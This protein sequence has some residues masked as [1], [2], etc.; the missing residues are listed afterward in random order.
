MILL[1]RWKKNLCLGI[2]GLL[3][4]VCL[5]SVVWSSDE[6]PTNSDPFPKNYMIFMLFPENDK[7]P[8]SNDNESEKTTTTL[9]SEGEKNPVNSLTKSLSVSSTQL[10]KKEK[11]DESLEILYPDD[12]YNYLIQYTIGQDE[13]MRSLSTFIHQHLM[14]VHL[15]QKAK[16]NPHDEDL[17]G[18]VIEKPNILMMGPTGCGKTSS[19]KE[20]SKLLKVPFATGNATEWTAQGYIGGKWQDTFDMLVSN[21]QSILTSQ[22]KPKGNGEVLKLASQGIVFID[23]FDKICNKTAGELEV[24]DRV[25]QELLPVIQGTEIKLNSGDYLDTSNILFIAGGAFPG[26]IPNHQDQETQK[27]SKKHNKTPDVIT[28]AHLEKYGMLPELAGRLCNIVQFSPLDKEALKK[29]ILNSKTSALKQSVKYY[30]AAYK[31]DLTID[32]M[33]V[34]YI[35]EAA[36][37]QK[38]GARG[39]NAMLYKLME[40]K[41]FNIKKYIG[42][43]VKITV[44]DARKVLEPYIKELK[45]DVNPSHLMMYT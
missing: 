20:V 32:D 12:I 11:E 25:Q 38:T 33:V 44:E 6:K 4:N 3:F 7:A 21:A 22:K 5:S 27:S 24:I 34:D 19:L 29:I 15:R 14:M 17:K 39:I 37:R 9:T 18:L 1:P 23:E 35:A 30:K 13:A 2:S 31:I 40:E 28:P 10:S 16:D 43:P 26:L 45:E 42:N 8:K 41:S 36:L